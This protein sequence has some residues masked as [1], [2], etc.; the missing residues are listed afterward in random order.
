M[1]AISD[2]GNSRRIHQ[3][4]YMRSYKAGED[5]FLHHS[6]CS[7]GPNSRTATG[8]AEQGS[9]RARQCAGSPEGKCAVDTLPAFNAKVPLAKAWA[10]L[11]PRDETWK[12]EA[13]DYGT[14]TGRSI[15]RFLAVSD[16]L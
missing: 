16:G 13:G 7:V 6:R 5:P 11:W 12:N 15:G 2:S 14:L 8:L 3:I 9:G 1:H 4:V 10:A